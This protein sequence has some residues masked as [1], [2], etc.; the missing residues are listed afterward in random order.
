MFFDL[1]HCTRGLDYNKHKVGVFGFHDD[2]Q[3]D[4]GV[5]TELD[6]LAL[7]LMCSMPVLTLA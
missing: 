2:L 3:S 6:T 5:S 1:S 7:A 4:G